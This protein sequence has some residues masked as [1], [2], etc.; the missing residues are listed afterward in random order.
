M[1]GRRACGPHCTVQYN[2]PLLAP[3]STN[4]DWNSLSSLLYVWMS[5]HQ[6]WKS[7]WRSDVSSLEFAAARGCHQRE[8]L[9][10]NCQLTFPEPSTTCVLLLAW[11]SVGE[12][13]YLPCPIPARPLGLPSPPFRD[14]WDYPQYQLYALWG[15]PCPCPGVF[16][17]FLPQFVL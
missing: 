8:A 14:L 12:P 3:Q 1:M 2:Y 10:D 5:I 11:H 9:R 16:E 4:K 7:I 15:C 6:V 17:Y 13:V